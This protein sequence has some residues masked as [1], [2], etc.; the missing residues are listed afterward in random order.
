MKVAMMAV[1]KDT[2]M[3]MAAGVMIEVD[4]MMVSAM[5]EVIV[6]MVDKAMFVAVIILPPLSFFLR[7]PFR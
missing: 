4:V 5:I 7:V 1:A 2:I 3:M 6:M